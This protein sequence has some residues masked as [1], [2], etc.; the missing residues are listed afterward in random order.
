MED[1]SLKTGAVVCFEGKQYVITTPLDLDSVLGKDIETGEPRRLPIKN[2]M[3]PD[4]T[5]PEKTTSLDL[6]LVTDKDWEEANKR[7]EIIRPLINNSHRSIS[8]IEERA[9][10]AGVK[11][12]TIYRWIEAYENNPRISSL[13]RDRSAGG[14]GEHRIDKEVVSIMDATIDEL[15]LRRKDKKKQAIQKTCDE[16]I[17]RCRRAKLPAPHPNTVRKRIVILA[18][19]E[20]LK[21]R[22][23][24]RTGKNSVPRKGPFPDADWPLSVVQMDH[25]PLDIIVVDDI[26]RL[27]VGRPWITLAICVFSR[28]IVGFYISFDAPSSLSVGMC[29]SFAILPKEKWLAKHDIPNPWPIWGKMNRIHMDNAMEFHGKMLDKACREYG[30]DPQYRPVKKPNF[31]G[32]IERLCGTLLKEIH[33]LPGTTFSNPTERGDYDSE[34]HAV[35]TLTELEKW[36]AELITGKYHQ[37]VHSELGISP[38]KKFEE[39][40]FG[41]KDRPGVGIPDRVFDEERL[42]LDFLPYYERTVQDY[43][44]V[45]DDIHYYNNDLSP[46]IDAKE[47]G[48]NTRRKF[49]VRQD[50]RDISVVYFLDPDLNVYFEIPYRDTSRPAISKWEYKE[51]KRRLI[52]E[53]AKDINEDLIF[54]TYERMRA[55]QEEATTKT[56]KARRAGQR[57]REHKKA[58]QEFRQSVKMNKPDKS[59]DEEEISRPISPAR[60]IEPFADIDENFE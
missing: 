59:E 42:R 19:K 55:I 2:L 11:R 53:G 3:P 39:G 7:F 28:V 58:V 54:A 13:L 50:P 51:A 47:P 5:N 36:L 41:T 29:L 40:I 30:I 10:E 4:V 1:I 32:H 20:I 16:V 12:A 6:A 25:T 23:E 56:K 21:K 45:I 17:A 18:E 34:K 22:N 31:G 14:R 49:I 8:M 15:Q 33:D 43:G 57:R 24:Q 37:R 35:F 9:K 52:E 27:P 46:W 26:D 48:N 60:K 38:L 44:I